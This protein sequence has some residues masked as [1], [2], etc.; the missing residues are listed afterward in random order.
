MKLPRKVNLKLKYKVLYL[1]ETSN[2]F[3]KFPFFFSLYMSYL[4]N[5]KNNQHISRISQNRKIDQSKTVTT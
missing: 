2:M 5:I 3:K 1:F 4:Y